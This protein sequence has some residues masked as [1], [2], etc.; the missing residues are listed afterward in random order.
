MSDIIILTLSLFEKIKTMKTIVHETIR[1]LEYICILGIKIIGL[2]LLL[3]LNNGV[4]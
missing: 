4:T 3:L 2:F 1:E